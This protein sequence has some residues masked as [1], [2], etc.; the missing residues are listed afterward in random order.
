MRAWAADPGSLDHTAFLGDIQAVGKGRFAQR[1]ATVIE[2]SGSDA[3][4]DYIERALARVT[5]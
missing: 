3:C 2:E 4:P 5:E 1:L